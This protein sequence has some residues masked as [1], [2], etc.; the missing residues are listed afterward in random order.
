MRYT[1]ILYLLPFITIGLLVPDVAAAQGK[2]FVTC[3][4]YFLNPG[5]DCNFCHFVDMINLIIRW[6]IGILFVIFAIVMVVAGFKLVTSAGDV[7]ARDRAKDMFVNAIIGI[8]IVFAAWLLIDTIMKAILNGGS[9]SKMGDDFGM[10][11]EIQCTEQF[12]PLSSGEDDPTPVPPNTPP[13]T[14]DMCNDDQELMDRYGGSPVGQEA[15]GLQDMISCYLN[16]PE[17]AAATDMGQLYTTDR[18]HPRCSLTNGSQVCGSCSHSNNS[19]HYGRGSGRGAMAVDF[20]A[21]GGTTEQELYQLLR[22]RSSTCGGRLGFE[23][24]HTHISM[25]SC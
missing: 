4:G 6:L 18:S 11:N 24:N 3:D 5:G 7:T 12:N 21:A 1:T 10:W 25:D 15:P 2:G 17:I 19:C 23:S 20:N 14:P 22:A 9:L 8:I 13:P 16:D